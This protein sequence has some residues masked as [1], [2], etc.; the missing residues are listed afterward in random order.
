MYKNAVGTILGRADFKDISQK[1]DEKE[2]E[3]K[4][5]E[6][7]LRKLALDRHCLHDKWATKLGLVHT[8]YSAERA[9]SS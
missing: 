6:Q 9:L 7:F 5:I 8:L 4:R 3:L 1:R 2:A